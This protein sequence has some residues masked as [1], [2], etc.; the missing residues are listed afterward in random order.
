VAVAGDTLKVVNGEV[1]INGKPSEFVNPSF[2]YTVYA[3]TTLVFDEDLL[4]SNGVHV[5]NNAEA[6]GG[7]V[8][9]TPLGN[10]Q[11]SV[12]L[13]KKE[14]A[15]VKAIPGV[16]SVTR[17]LYPSPS[18]YPYMY[19]GIKIFNWDSENFGGN[20]LWIPKKGATIKLTTE[21]IALY[22]RVIAVYE[23]NAW[24]ERNGKVFINDKE[25]DS[26]TFKM[27]YYWMMG[28]NRHKSQDSRFWGFVP[29]DHVVGKASLIWFSWEGGPR[30][31]RMFRSIK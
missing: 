5:N 18:T 22:K 19:T 31:K 2:F 6:E 12:N 11:Y 3:K 21:N 30:W 1:F 14:L 8:D 28:D 15:I 20:G 29:E 24:E 26:Y 4:K 25:A 17:T 27:D 9:Y 16:D 7:S 13:S 10:G 23:G